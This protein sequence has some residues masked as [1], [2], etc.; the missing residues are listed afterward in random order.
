MIRA[1]KNTFLTTVVCLSLAA[2]AGMDAKAGD[3]AVKPINDSC[4]LMPDH[5]VDPDVTVEYEGHTIAFCCKK[6]VR[7]WNEKMSAEERAAFVK[8]AMMK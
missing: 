4:P 2:C 7:G 3:M 1:L 6:C 5:G 8:Q